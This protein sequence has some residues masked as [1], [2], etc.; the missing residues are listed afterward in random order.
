MRATSTAALHALIGG[1]AFRA[2]IVLPSDA[3]HMVWRG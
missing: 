1:F 3:A 2:V